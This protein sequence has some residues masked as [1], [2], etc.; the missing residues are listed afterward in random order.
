MVGT[1]RAGQLLGESIAVALAVR[2]PHEG[3]DD[4]ERPVLDPGGLAP[5][6]GEPQ[7]DVE[8]EQVDA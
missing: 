8:L 7:V 5:E 3:S 4:L 6:V 1:E 2:R